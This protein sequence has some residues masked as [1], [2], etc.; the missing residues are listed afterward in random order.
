MK[1][2]LEAGMLICFGISWPI[3]VIKSYK[4]RTNKG[5]SVIFVLF[6]LIGYILGIVSKIVSGNINYVIIFYAFNL[7]MVSIDFLLYLRNAKID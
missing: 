5:K 7:V 3:S 4:A 2:I 1:E 6:I